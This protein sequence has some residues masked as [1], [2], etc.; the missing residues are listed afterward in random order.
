MPFAF[1]MIDAFVVVVVAA[2]CF[3]L[4]MCLMRWVLLLLLSVSCF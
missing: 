3:S 2:V 1:D 4:L